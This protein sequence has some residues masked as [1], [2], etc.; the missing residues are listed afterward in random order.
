MRT[1]KRSHNIPPISFQ[2]SKGDF[3][4][5]NMVRTDRQGCWKRPLLLRFRRPCCE[6]DYRYRPRRLSP[7]VTSSVC[8]R[9]R[10]GVGRGLGATGLLSTRR[11]SRL[12][13]LIP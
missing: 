10:R 2:T 9:V 3:R 7:T 5:S 1:L 13:N 11:T 8:M 12:I 6:T 4:R